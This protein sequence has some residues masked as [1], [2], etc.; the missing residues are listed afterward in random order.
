M[1]TMIEPITREE[2]LARKLNELLGTASEALFPAVD[3]VSFIDL[4]S[5]EKLVK[6]MRPE[7][8]FAALF[9]GRPL[10]G[11]D[12][13][14]RYLR[15]AFGLVREALAYGEAAVAKGFPETVKPKIV[16]IKYRNE[17]KA[18]AAAARGGILFPI[19]FCEDATF[20]V[21]SV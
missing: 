5:Y 6:G 15:Q 21:L 19:G 20:I 17:A 11:K 1:N 7:R 4:E 3:R 9:L 18:A 10:P 12:Q 2:K 13:V 16:G 8:S 14:P